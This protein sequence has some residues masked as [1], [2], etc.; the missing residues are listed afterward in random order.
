MAKSKSS[1]ETS[2]GDKLFFV[3]TQPDEQAKENVP[4]IDAN[5]SNDANDA[6]NSISHLTL[7]DYINVNLDDPADTQ[8][9]KIRVLDGDDKEYTENESDFVDVD[10]HGA[11]PVRYFQEDVNRHE[12]TVC[13]TCKQTG[14]LSKD[15]PHIIC[16]TC[17]AVDEHRERDCPISLVCYNCGGRGHF[18]RNCTVPKQKD[19]RLSCRRCGSPSHQTRACLTLWRIYQYVD[20]EHFDSKP[21][22]ESK[23]DAERKDIQQARTEMWCYNCADSGHLGDDC[24]MRRGCPI[25]L[26]EPS[27][28]SEQNLFSGPF[29]TALIG[30]KKK[31][32][33]GSNGDKNSNSNTNAYRRAK[34]LDRASGYPPN[35]RIPDRGG[36]G[37]ERRRKEKEHLKRLEESS[38]DSDDYDRYVADIN[39]IGQGPPRKSRKN[40]SGQRE[41]RRGKDS[42]RE[43][44]GSWSKNE[45]DKGSD[46]DSL[47]DSR[48][49]QAPNP[50]PPRF[51]RYEDNYRSYKNIDRPKSTGSRSTWRGG[52][53]K[54]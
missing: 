13:R 24:D 20:A 49:R 16:L 3:D 19:S 46:R 34:H 32:R 42:G 29:K 2:A 37:S 15:C 53:G 30:D 21:Q 6:D 40:R 8:N 50:P 45:V 54:R 22:K 47:L 39:G 5:D 48:R 12:Y 10:Q 28:F 14:H 26:I 7:P 51:G 18:A 44:G 52:Y 41:P 25:P 11:G 38:D 9:H 27:A 43:S 31:G 33:N 35:T 1:D 17:G 36:P 23:D 4:A